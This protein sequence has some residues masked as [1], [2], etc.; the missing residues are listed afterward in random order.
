MQ[1]IE[2]AQEAKEKDDEKILLGYANFISNAERDGLMTFSTID[3]HDGNMS[4][5]LRN[6]LHK[7]SCVL[8]LSRDQGKMSMDEQV[9]LTSYSCVC[10]NVFGSTRSRSFPNVA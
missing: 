1:L 4:A 9:R 7:L 3:E 10:T 8:H 5:S 2:D 6:V